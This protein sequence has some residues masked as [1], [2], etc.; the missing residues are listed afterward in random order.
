VV[1]ERLYY[2]SHLS[3]PRSSV[4]TS[5]ARFS[6][7]QAG[8]TQ[9]RPGQTPMLEHGS[10]VYATHGNQ[11]MGRREEAP[12]LRAQMKRTFQQIPELVDKRIDSASHA[13]LQKYLEN[14]LNAVSLEETI[15]ITA[16]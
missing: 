4:V 9:E 5:S 11:G 15:G 1:L 13:E 2:F 16:G 3:F 10:Q 8:W 12:T 6:V 14:I 7:L